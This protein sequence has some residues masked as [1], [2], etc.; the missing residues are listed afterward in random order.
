MGD[1]EGGARLLRRQRS[2]ALTKRNDEQQQAITEVAE[3]AEA[4]AAEAAEVVGKHYHCE[5][6]AVLAGA[7]SV[8]TYL[9]PSVRLVC[10]LSH[11][12]LPRR[13]VEVLHPHRICALSAL[14]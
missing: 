7:H 12:R 3:A 9:V 5:E 1:E 6:A 11:S 13:A 10:Q 2:A 14:P 8:C 4:E